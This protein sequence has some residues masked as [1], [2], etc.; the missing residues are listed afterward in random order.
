M[1]K[2]KNI[3]WYH[4]RYEAYE[5]RVI[6][7]KK[8]IKQQENELEK[9][10][11]EIDVLIE[12]QIHKKR[13]EETTLKSKEKLFT[14]DVEDVKYCLVKYR[15]FWEH[16][17]WEDRLK[18]CFDNNIKLRLGNVKKY[19]INSLTSMKGRHISFLK[20]KIQNDEKRL[21]KSLKAQQKF[22]KEMEIEGIETPVL[23]LA[24]IE[25]EVEKQLESE[26]ISS[27]I[28]V[29]KPS[30][31]NIPF[32]KQNLE[33]FLKATESPESIKN[34]IDDDEQ[35]ISEII[36]LLYQIFENFKEF[37]CP[38]CYTLYPEKIKICERCGY[39]FTKIEL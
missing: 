30:L 9:F 31:P 23:N 36:N 20:T 33:K 28:R 37:V 2:K 29:D 3:E 13:L 35:E 5:R 15:N 32:F 22:K 19:L 16:A 27:P 18:Y 21:T 24:E 7:L 11:E 12:D 8:L 38:K 4:L 1:K 34:L 17:F 6:E 25:S 14:K 10:R 39:D 26:K